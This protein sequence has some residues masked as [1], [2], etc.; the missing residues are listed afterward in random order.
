MSIFNDYCTKM[1]V[2]QLS[3]KLGFDTKILENQGYLVDDKISLSSEIILSKDVNEF[4]N[5]L[6]LINYKMFLIVGL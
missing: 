5:L 3:E 6:T 4:Y 2:T 1:S